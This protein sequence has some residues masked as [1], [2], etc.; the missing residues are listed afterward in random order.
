MKQWLLAILALLCLVAPAT[1]QTA[2]PL[3]TIHVGVLP[4]EVAG[5]AYYAT[6]LGIFKKY[7]LDVQLE[8]M[9]NGSVIAT[10]IANGSIDI[11]LADLVYVASAHAHG[12]PLVYVAPGL[13]T[14]YAAPAFGILVRNDSTIRDAKTL[15]GKN[16]RR[17]CAQ[18]YRHRA[19]AR[20][21]RT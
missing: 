18:W 12:F 5:E 1:A 13:M 7:G 8:P 9:A 15:A 20:V 11:G 3:K 19:D 10:A 6:D 17:G 16:H 2:P 14:S 4:G 21:G